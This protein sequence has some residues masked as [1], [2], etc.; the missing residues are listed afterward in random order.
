LGESRI[1]GHPDQRK[2]QRKSQHGPRKTT[3]LR[4]AR[5]FALAW[6]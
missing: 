4:L 1:A 2:E 6:M 5:E 3:G